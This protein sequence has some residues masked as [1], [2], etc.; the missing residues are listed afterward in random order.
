[1]PNPA[2]VYCEEQGGRVEIRI[3]PEII[4]QADQI[5]ASFAL[6]SGETPQLEFTP[7]SP[8]N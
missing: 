6:T 5:I 4:A 3:P 8:S 2:S 7:P 1:L